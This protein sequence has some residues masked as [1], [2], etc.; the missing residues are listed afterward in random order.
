[1]WEAYAPTWRPVVAPY[2]RERGVVR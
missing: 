2:L 1:V